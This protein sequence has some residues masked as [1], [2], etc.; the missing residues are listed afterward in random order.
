MQI[1]FY[2]AARNVTGSKHLIT[3]TKG[4][5]VLLD[6]GFFQNRGKDNDR[7]NR[8]FAFNPSDIDVL[9]LSHAHIDH[10]G[11]IPNLVK[12]GFKG[13]IYATQATID[14][15]SIMLT[16]SAFIQ[17]SDIEYINKKRKHNGQPKLEPIYDVEDVE[18]TMTYFKPIAIGEWKKIDDEVSF[19]FTD[20][21][22]ILGSATVNLKL[23]DNGNVK[24]LTFSGD[25]GRYH[26]LIL[27][28]PAA[29]PQADYILCEST[30]GN[31]LHD[32]SGDARQK[33]LDIVLDT[34]T[35][36]KGKLII[37]AFS[38]GRTQ[39]II[40]TLD[41]YKTEGKLPDIP[42]F[43]DSPLAID[44]TNIMRKHCEFFNLEVRKY[45]KTDPDPFGFSSLHYVRKVEESKKINDYNGPCIIIS[46]SGMIEAGRIKH[47]IK[48]NIQNPRN[49]ILIVG[50]CTPQSTGGQLMNGAETVK[51]FGIEY[52]VKAKVEVISSFSAH[53]DYGELQKYLSC[54]DISKVRKLFLVHGE[55]EVQ[56][57]FKEKLIEQGFQHIEIP[58][59][60]QS[61]N[62]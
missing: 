43:V 57:D 19:Q 30:Y 34:C 15:C 24:H 36:R 54:Q 55:Y 42:V 25:V 31:R 4:K 33:L 59:E 26:D 17:Q 46:A 2:G 40:Y 58:E 20:A 44:A 28:P 50:Y 6:C 22:H 62:L 23:T 47:H 7:V 60:G 61:F 35:I 37:P 29:F 32:Y 9:I 45:M 1:T 21:G 41:R 27:K 38:L 48:N 5:T 53:A 16:D 52:P 56:L 18:R 3:T 11:N 49:T 12:Q 14:L 8:H 39:E 51:I 13:T 10:S